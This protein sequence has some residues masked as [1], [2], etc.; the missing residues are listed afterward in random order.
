MF[1]LSEFEDTIRIHPAYYRSSL[2]VALKNELNKKFSNKVVHDLG[3]CICLYEIKDVG[4]GM[5][6]H[7]DGLTYYKSKVFSTQDSS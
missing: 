6:H 4:D 7:S 3:L 2:Y 1:M 5:I